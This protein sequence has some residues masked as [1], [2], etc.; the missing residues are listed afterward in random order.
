MVVLRSLPLVLTKYPKF[1][2]LG[3]SIFGPDIEATVPRLG[4]DLEAKSLGFGLDSIFR[5]SCTTMF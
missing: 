4:F 3:L 2:L 1:S 5:I